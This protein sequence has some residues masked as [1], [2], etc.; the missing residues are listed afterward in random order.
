MVFVCS[1]SLQGFYKFCN[2]A[3]G[4]PSRTAESIR[5]KKTQ[6]ILILAGLRG[7][8]SLALVE[9]V[10]I[11]NNMTGEGC[12]FKPLMKGMTSAAI[13]F[14][15]FIFGGGAYYI[16]PHLGIEPAVHLKP[17]TADSALS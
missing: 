6:A 10:P 3:K 16:L 13:L 4:R 2:S 11:Y 7:A 8:V 12:E 5:D 1:W 9:N 14:T 15:T 17:P